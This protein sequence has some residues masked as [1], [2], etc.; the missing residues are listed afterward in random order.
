MLAVCDI[1]VGNLLTALA[2]FALFAH[3]GIGLAPFVASRPFHLSN[4]RL[5]DYHIEFLSI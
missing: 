4:R 2:L 1:I 3:F 5:S